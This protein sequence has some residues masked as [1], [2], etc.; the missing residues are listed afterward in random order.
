MAVCPPG[1]G[2]ESFGADGFF[3]DAPS[4]QD[5]LPKV[6]PRFY[7]IRSAGVFAI[8]LLSDCLSLLSLQTPSLLACLKDRTDLWLQEPSL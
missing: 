4:W 5:M 2:F 1:I 3:K 8:M 6:N 7:V